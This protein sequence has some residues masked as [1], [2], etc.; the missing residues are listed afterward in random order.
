MSG[1][2][3]TLREYL[4]FSLCKTGGSCIQFVDFFDPAKHWLG[5]RLTCFDPAAD[6]S[7]APKDKLTVPLACGEHARRLR[8]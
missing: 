6:Y 2:D 8:S 4:H 3:N 1:R 5:D 7:A